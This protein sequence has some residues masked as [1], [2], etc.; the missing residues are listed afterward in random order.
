MKSSL[1]SHRIVI[2]P[3]SLP[4]WAPRT[5]RRLR[6]F[7]PKLIEQH[8]G[9]LPRGSHIQAQ[10]V[11]LLSAQVLLRDAGVDGKR[12]RCANLV[13]RCGGGGVDFWGHGAGLGDGEGEGCG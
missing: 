11:H 7:I 13:K 6:I 5:T 10:T 12:S 9:I 3:L 2:S 4:L 8:P 1:Q